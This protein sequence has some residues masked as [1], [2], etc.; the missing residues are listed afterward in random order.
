MSQFI[1]RR[2]EKLFAKQ[3]FTTLNRK[4]AALV[5]KVDIRAIDL[6]LIMK[7]I[8][9]EIY[10]FVSRSE[11]QLVLRDLY[12]LPVEERANFVET[13]LLNKEILKKRGVI[14]P[15]GLVIQ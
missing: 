10:D 6:D 7:E 8:L 3:H 11:F 4:V 14:A 15:E 1:C 12:S 2:N 5:N 9:Q 13:V